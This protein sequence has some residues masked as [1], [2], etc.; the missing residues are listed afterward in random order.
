[1]IP[2]AEAGGRS[3]LLQTIQKE[4]GDRKHLKVLIYPC[5]S[6]Q[7]FNHHEQQ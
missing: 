3:D 5:A 2:C 1:M 7:C 4:Q 6:L